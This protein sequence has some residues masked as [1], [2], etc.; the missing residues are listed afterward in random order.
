MVLDYYFGRTS[1]P[2]QDVSQRLFGFNLTEIIDTLSD[3]TL[4][5]LVAQL[6]SPGGQLLVS[7]A[8][9]DDRAAVNALGDRLG[10]LGGNLTALNSEIQVCCQRPR[11]KD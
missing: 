4:T 3:A 6:Q 2:P 8:S 11:R 1:I 7:T 10:Y 5:D 9:A